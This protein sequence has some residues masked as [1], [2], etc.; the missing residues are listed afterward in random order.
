MILYNTTFVIAEDLKEKFIS[1]AKEQ[2]ISSAVESGIFSSPILSRIL[3]SPEP[4]TIAF[5][6]QM[7]GN[8]YDNAVK[9]HDTYGDDMRK[10]CTLKWGECFL[11][12]STFME[13]VK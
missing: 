13:I 8:N 3:S 5:A 4:G 7:R 1:W 9:W 11:H 6:L 2:Y 12:F 10:I